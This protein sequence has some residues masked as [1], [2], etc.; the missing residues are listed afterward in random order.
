MRRRL[1]ELV[2]GLVLGLVWCWAILLLLEH[3]LRLLGGVSA[4]LLIG[5]GF[6]CVVG[7]GRQLSPL[8]NSFFETLFVSLSDLLLQFGLPLALKQLLLLFGVNEGARSVH[9][10]SND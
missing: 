3:G 10:L 9:I 6:I 2:L 7:E 4:F 5:E 8:S 1:L